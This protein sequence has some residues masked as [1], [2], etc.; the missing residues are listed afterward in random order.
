LVENG[1]GN[2]SDNQVAAITSTTVEPN[3][4]RAKTGIV[5][6]LN[7]AI[8]ADLSASS[9]AVS[10]SYSKF[11]EEMSE[12]FKTGIAKIDEL[13]EVINGYKTDF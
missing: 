3:T 11:G 2:Y 1:K 4:S 10:S 12:S 6:C 8:C 5:L 7:E 13:I 9:N